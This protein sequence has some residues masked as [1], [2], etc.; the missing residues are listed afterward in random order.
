M[1]YFLHHTHDINAHLHRAATL[2]PHGGR[3]YVLDRVAVDDRALDAFP[4]YWEQLY[5]ASHEW[6]ED[7]PRLATVEQLTEAAR[8][9]GF[10]FVRHQV[11]P[12]DRRP[13]TEGFPKTLMEFWR[14]ES[15]KSFPPVMVVS[16]AHQAHVDEICRQLA[17]AGLPVAG[18][19]PVQYSDALIRTIYE[20]CP[21][22]E[23]L[24]R[25]VGDTS[26]ERVATALFIL[27]DDTRPGLLECLSQFKKIHRDRWPNIVG[28]AEPDGMQA[29]ILPFHVPEPYE[30]EA[31][32]R[33][34]GVSAEFI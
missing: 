31:L 17:L 34:V 26:P 23:L 25:F 18:K 9:A 22:R 20:R 12:H 28:P 5:R 27:G 6:N 24:R 19:L 7:M 13:G 15:G 4:L 14:H 21:W 10:D 1:S 8:H 16:P 33:V 32:A 29:I 2:L 11:C 30:A 3:L